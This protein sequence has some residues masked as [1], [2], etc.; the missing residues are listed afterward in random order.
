L[1]KTFNANNQL[2]R[3][4]NQLNW[5]DSKVNQFQA[6]SKPISKTLSVK[7]PI[8]MIK[9]QVVFPKEFDLNQLWILT[10]SGLQI[11]STQNPHTQA[12]AKPS[13]NLHGF[14]DIKAYLQ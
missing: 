12:A 2:K 13:T 11:Q 5:F 1:L 7:Q 14:R 10:Q 8:E 3:R 4:N 6:L 9:Q